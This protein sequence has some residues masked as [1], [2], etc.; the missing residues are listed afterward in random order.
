MADKRGAGK[1]R[2][3][4]SDELSEGYNADRTKKHKEMATSAPLAKL[5]Q[6]IRQR[7]RS[8][9]LAE[10]GLADDVFEVGGCA[11]WEA[12]ATAGP[13]RGHG[14]VKRRTLG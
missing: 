2:A 11:G 4:A 5:V 8:A 12:R 1:R 10:L 6:D 14:T 9:T 7:P 3:T 13:Q